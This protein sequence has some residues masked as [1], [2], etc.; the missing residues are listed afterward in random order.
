LR[1]RLMK[2]FSGKL[3]VVTGGGSGIGR[4]L[5]LQLAA[6]GCSVATC[7]LD[8]E[9]LEETLAKANGLGVSISSY[10]CDVA[11][12][13]SVNQFRDSVLQEHSSEA[14]NLLFNNAGIEGGYEFV[15]GDRGAWERTFNVCWGGVYN[16]SRAF[17]PALVRSSE[18]CVINMGSTATFWATCGS[19]YS[20]AKFA[21]RGFSE[22]LVLELRQ[23]A[24]HVTVVLPSPQ[25]VRTNIDRNTFRI[26]G[27]ENNA[28]FVG[29]LEGK[30][31]PRGASLK[32]DTEDER[33]DHLFSFLS[34]A[35]MGPDEVAAAILEGVKSGQWRV[36]IGDWTR[37]VDEA[38]R[39]NPAGAYDED[40]IAR[41]YSPV[42][43][44]DFFGDDV[45]GDHLELGD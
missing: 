21:V 15:E 43:G 27:D 38:V 28:D 24:P 34:E 1:R 13:A 45:V 31:V 19:A 30:V 35:G 36:L 9:A 6:S 8:S 20:T 11:D 3:A 32:G 25:A 39:A 4:E 7:D 17:M 10:I 26:L 44:V 5:V 29:V 41:L 16:C 12:E 42:S 18:G 2:S 23:K 40:F 22:A 37:L 14:I 33:R